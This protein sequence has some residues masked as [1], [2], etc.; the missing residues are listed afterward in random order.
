MFSF[1]LWRFVSSFMCYSL[2][3]FRSGVYILLES[4]VTMT[5]LFGCLDGHWGLC[6]YLSVIFLSRDLFTVARVFSSLSMVLFYL[7]FLC[8]SS[9]WLFLFSE[10]LFLFLSPGGF[11]FSSS[12]FCFLLLFPVA[13]SIVSLLSGRCHSKIIAHN[14]MRSATN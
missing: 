12:S 2:I 6:W 7:Y 14:S 4:V 1:V 3:L 9:G 13:L 10:L 8:S 5:F 11:Y